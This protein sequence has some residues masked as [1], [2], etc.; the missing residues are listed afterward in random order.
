MT[1]YPMP[2]PEIPAEFADMIDANPEGF[3]D[4]MAAGTEAMGAAMA[5]GASP[6]DAFEAMGDIMGP[7]MED[8]GVSPEAFD[9]MGDMMGAGIGGAMHMAPGDASPADMGAIMQDGLDYMM[10]EG[11]DCPPAI[12]EAMGDMG[13]VMGD[14]GMSCHDVGAAMMGDP[15]SA[16]YLLPVDGDGNAVVEAGQPETCPAEA[17]QPPPADG[18]CATSAPDM[19][20]PE[21]G[22]D[23]APT[24]DMVLSEPYVMDYGD[25]EAGSDTSAYDGMASG[26]AEAGSDTSAYD[27]MA[28]GVADAGSDTSAY[29]DCEAGVDPSG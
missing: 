1:M 22:Y 18:A 16:T 8:M 15:G 11:V 14:S 23:H 24:G 17:V 27:G 12:M 25:A 7:M 10:P 5:N 13:S 19:M 26:D 28:S 20:P 9:A 21:G 6:E 2:M 4:A 29:V 3:A